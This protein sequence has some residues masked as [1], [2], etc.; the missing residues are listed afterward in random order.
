MVAF[1]TGQNSHGYYAIPSLYQQY[2]FIGMGQGFEVDTRGTLVVDIID[3]Q[4]GRLAWHAWT[5]KGI[6]PGITYGKKITALVR[7]AVADVL[8]AFPPH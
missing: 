4:S 7:E 1:S 8:A 6:G 2:G 3:T 5:T